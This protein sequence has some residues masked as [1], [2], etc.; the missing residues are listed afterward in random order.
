MMGT[1]DGMGGAWV[2]WPMLIIGLG[3]LA[4]LV[5]R[6]LGGGVSRGE[7]DPRSSGSASAPPPAVPNQ[8]DPRDLR[9][10]SVTRYRKVVFGMGMAMGGHPSMSSTFPREARSSCG[11]PSRTSA[12]GPSIAVTSWTTRT[13]P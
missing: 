4:V 1:G 2:F 6:V 3:F 10:E 9:K 12:A 11:S 5:V 7:P 8:P 13:W